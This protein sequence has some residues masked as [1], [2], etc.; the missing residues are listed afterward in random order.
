MTARGVYR[1]RG[2]SRRRVQ[3]VCTLPP[4]DDLLFSNTTGILQKKKTMWFIGVEVEQETSA[5]PPKKNSGSALV[6]SSHVPWKFPWNKWRDIL[7]PSLRDQNKSQFNLTARRLGSGRFL[8]DPK[9]LKLWLVHQME[10][11]ISV[12]S[13]GNIRYFESGQLWPVWPFR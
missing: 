13:N 3:G 6:A 8:F 7:V 9:F 2:G 1:F 11:T 12:W 4:W 10:R 5:P